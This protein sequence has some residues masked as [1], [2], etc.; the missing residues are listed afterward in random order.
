MDFITMAYDKH[1]ASEVKKVMAA[2]KEWLLRSVQRR[3]RPPQQKR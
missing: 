1:D 2:V 3:W